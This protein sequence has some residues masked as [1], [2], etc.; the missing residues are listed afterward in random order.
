LPYFSYIR[1]ENEILIKARLE[2][3]FNMKDG[4]RRERQWDNR[5]DESLEMPAP[6]LPFE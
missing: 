4:A 5:L 3:T 1:L 2:H 6:E